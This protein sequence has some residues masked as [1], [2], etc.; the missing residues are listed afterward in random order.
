MQDVGRHV[1]MMLES[2][3]IKGPEVDEAD[4]QNVEYLRKKYP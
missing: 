1:G 4:E 3:A 2:E